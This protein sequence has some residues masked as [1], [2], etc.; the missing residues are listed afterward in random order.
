MS[1]LTRMIRAA[2][3]GLRRRLPATSHMALGASMLACAALLQAAS[4]ARAAAPACAAAQVSAITA[5]VTCP[6]G[7]DGTWTVRGG[8][9][10]AT[11]GR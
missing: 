6:V 3:D 7:V 11:F 8:V 4:S 2:G 9:S 10:Q 1:P 5:T